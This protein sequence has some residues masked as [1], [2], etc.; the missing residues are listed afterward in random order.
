MW[1]RG[2]SRLERGGDG[3]LSASGRRPPATCQ[4]YWIK[5]STQESTW[6]HPNFEKYQRMLRMAAATT[7]QGAA[8]LSAL[9]SQGEQLK[10]I[11]KEQQ[12]IH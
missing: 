7:E 8:T 3:R 9:H 6:T 2:P 4:V 5:Q 10:A 11:N 12:Q 1:A